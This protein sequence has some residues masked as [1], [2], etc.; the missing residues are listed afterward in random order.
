MVTGVAGKHTK[1]E[2]TT[3]SR[4]SGFQLSRY[5]LW[6]VYVAPMAVWGYMQICFNIKAWRNTIASEYQLGIFLG[7]FLLNILYMLYYL[8]LY[9]Y[10]RKA[11]MITIGKRICIFVCMLVG[12][13][14]STYVNA[15]TQVPFI[16]SLHL[17]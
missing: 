1:I 5:L 17:R 10:L 15:P 11:D 16:D 3:A 6:N 12:V 7:F 9:A 8:Q 4:E 13:L 2:K 14:F